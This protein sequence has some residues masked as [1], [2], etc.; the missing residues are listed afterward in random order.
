MRWF[1]LA[2]TAFICLW[3]LWLLLLA[4][5]VVGKPRGQDPKYNASIQYWSPTFKALGVLGIIVIILEVLDL[6]VERL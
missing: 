4:Y 5:G 3:S 1:S 6:V 2:G